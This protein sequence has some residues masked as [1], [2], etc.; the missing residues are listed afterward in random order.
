M[1]SEA[2]RGTRKTYSTRDKGCGIGVVAHDLR[3]LFRRLQA[4]ERS[5]SRARTLWDGKT[6]LGPT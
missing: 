1:M 4:S 6:P 5:Q 2:A 3:F